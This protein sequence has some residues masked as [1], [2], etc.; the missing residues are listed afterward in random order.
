MT[1]RNFSN[2][3]IEYFEHRTDELL[4]DLSG[5]IA[6]PS[7]RDENAKSP[8]HRLVKVLEKRLIT[9]LILPKEKG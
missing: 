7:V 9:L 3:A 5:L 6:I 2:L 1:E 4:S 8:T